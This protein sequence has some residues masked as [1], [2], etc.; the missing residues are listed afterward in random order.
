M[1]SKKKNLLFV[2]GLD[3]QFGH[4]RL[5]F[6]FIF[7]SL[8]MSNGDRRD[9]FFYP[10]FSFTINSYILYYVIK[11]NG[12]QVDTAYYRYVCVFEKITALLVAMQDYSDHTMILTNLSCSAY[13]S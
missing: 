12:K 7:T 13:M 2:W 8:V 9:G 3:R 1:V 11:P 4:S 5:L 6:V 10:T